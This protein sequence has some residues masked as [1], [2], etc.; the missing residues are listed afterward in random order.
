MSANS[1]SHDVLHVV[2]PQGESGLLGGAWQSDVAVNNTE[3]QVDEEAEEFGQRTSRKMADPKSPSPDEV[4]EHNLN[5]LPYRSWC[6]H[7]VKGK[8]K[9]NSHRR[10]EDEPKMNEVH[11]DYAFLR[12]LEWGKRRQCLSEGAGKARCSLRM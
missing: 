2:R 3:L 9:E 6:R 1:E 7:C 5:H 11:F 10:S 4:A 8:C 12:N